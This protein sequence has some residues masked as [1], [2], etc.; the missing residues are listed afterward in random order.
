ML[1]D[2]GGGAT[3]GGEPSLLW[4]FQKDATWYNA[5]SNTKSTHHENVVYSHGSSA[6]GKG[7]QSVDTP[8]LMYK[9]ELS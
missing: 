5:V 1:A 2:V 6:A 4:H 7:K 9:T 3:N 8:R